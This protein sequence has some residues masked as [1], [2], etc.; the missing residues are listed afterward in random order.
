MNVTLKQLRYAYAV[1]RLGSIAAAAAEMRI[2][3]SSITA[4]VD[5]LEQSLGV[6][7][8][9]RQ[10][11]RGVIPTPA[12]RSALAMIG[13]LLMQVSHFESELQSLAGAPTGT[14]RLG[15]YVTTA[16][17]IL[18]PLLS[19]FSERYPQARIDIREGDMEMIRELLT[20]G[21]IDLACTYR[22]GV[23]A[24]MEFR[25]LFPARPYALIPESDPLSREVSVSLADLCRRPFIL[26]ELPRTRPY[27]MGIFKEL[28]LTPN[29]AHSSRSSEIV[30]SL[31]AAGFGVSILNI[32][33]GKERTDGSG[34]RCLPI[35]DD[36]ATPDFGVAVM[37][38]VRRP[39]MS[40]AFIEL[41]ETLRNDGVFS[42]LTVPAT[43]DTP[44]KM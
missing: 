16:P 20:A 36:V 19:A 28:G 21:Q 43:G 7:I 11:A 38:G 8:F 14:I 26:L 30:R 12:G 10:P 17:F 37:P 6:D 34:L 24:G 5:A 41:C 35:S 2:S 32:R 27:F 25:P 1:G 31:V 4:A 44:H 15:C 18:P 22:D 9:I 23:D 3:Q 29:I 39:A 42:S 33:S 40:R 13:D